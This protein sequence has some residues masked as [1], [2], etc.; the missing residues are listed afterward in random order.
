LLL[1]VLLRFGLWVAP[2]ATLSCA[3]LWGSLFWDRVNVGVGLTSAEVRSLLLNLACLIGVSGLTVAG[4]LAFYP[5]AAS[6]WSL[7]IEAL[8][9]IATLIVGY[10]LCSATLRTI[11]REEIAMTIRSLR[12]T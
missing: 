11:A 12:P 3:L 9:S 6:W 2:M 4:F 7:I 8:L 10:L 1:A 5:S